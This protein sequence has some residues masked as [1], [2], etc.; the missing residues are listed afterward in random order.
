MS[1]T[2]DI[3][4]KIESWI[5]AFKAA[6]QGK[7]PVCPICNG[8]NVEVEAEE[9]GDKIGYVLITCNTCKKSGYFSRVDFNNFKGK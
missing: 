9:L 4:T 6:S 7:N 8:D 3:D 2:L 1:K 5:P